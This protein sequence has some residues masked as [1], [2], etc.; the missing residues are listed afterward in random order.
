MKKIAKWLVLLAIVL[1]LL[2]GTVF[3]YC[4]SQTVSI[5]LVSISPE[6]VL[7]ARDFL[8]DAAKPALK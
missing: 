2:A 3:D 4:R 8:W 1:L 6:T 5:E 7:P